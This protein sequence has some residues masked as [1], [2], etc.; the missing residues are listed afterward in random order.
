MAF[1]AINDSTGPN[2]LILTLLVFSAYLQMTEFDTPLLTI[3][4]RATIIKKAI[5]EI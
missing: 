4:Q 2:R 3:T 1:K 5:A